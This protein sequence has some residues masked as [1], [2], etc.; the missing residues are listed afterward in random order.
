MLSMNNLSITKFC[1][2]AA[3]TLLLACT[4]VG[5]GEAAKPPAVPAKIE[6][7]VS[8]ESVPAGGKAEASLQLTP[9]Q[10]V[11]INRYPKISLKI[12]ELEGV[13]GGAESKV[14]DDAPPP[15]E[16]TGGNYFDKVDPIKIVIAMDKAAKPGEHEIEAKLKYYYCVKKSG[17]CAP[18]RATVKIPIE[19]R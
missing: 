14:G 6:I 15:P 5:A 13:V 16:Q 4:L 9:I 10:G 19:V 11:A 3:A 1:F 18:K 8:P 12:A 2:A 7:S 17:F